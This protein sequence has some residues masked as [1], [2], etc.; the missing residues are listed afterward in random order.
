[1]LPEMA[2]G[3]SSPAEGFEPLSKIAIHKATVELQP[4]AFVQ[5]TPSLLGD[6]GEDTDRV[7]VKYGRTK[8]SVDDWIAVF[9]PADFN[10]GK[11]P[12]PASYPGEPLL[13][14]A[15]MKY[16]YANYSARYT[17]PGDGSIRF[18]LIDQRAD[19]AFALFTGGLENA[20][21]VAVSKPVA[22]RNPKAPVFP[23]LAHGK[24]DDE[25]AVTWTSG[26]DIAPVEKS[27]AEPANIEVLLQDRARA[28]GRVC[29]VGQALHVPCSAVDGAELAAA[30]HR[31]RRHGKGTAERDGS[32]EFANYQPGSLNTTDALVRDLDNYAHGYISQWDQF[33]A[34][35]APITATNCMIA[36]TVVTTRGTGPTPAGSS[37]SRTPAASAACWPGRDHVL[38]PGREQSQL[39]V[40]GGLR[41]VSVL[42]HRLRARLAGGHG[43]VQVHQALP[44]DGGPEAPALAHLH[45]APRPGLLLQRPVRHEGLLRGARGQREHAEAAVEV[46]RR[47]HFLR[48]R[49]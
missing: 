6:K 19:F 3:A 27:R 41:D 2:A 24:I 4:S 39:L 30:R 31:L 49:P 40:Q 17:N 45:G 5:A 35:V 21:L 28:A 43:A 34:Q 15:P 10:S 33:T 22:F 16:Q 12:N 36:S 37:T 48:P 18:Q 23:R 32:N 44:L 7:T 8:R 25:I 11:C 47:H 9:S 29:R 46:P 14:T 38:L 1:M 42:H 20:R 26:Y 13:C